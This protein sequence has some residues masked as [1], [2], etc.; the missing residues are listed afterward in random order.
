MSSQ[1]FC[2]SF[3][4]AP[5]LL[6][7]ITLPPETW[8]SILVHRIFFPLLYLHI[9]NFIFREE[10]AGLAWIQSFP[11]SSTAS[12]TYIESHHGRLTSLSRRL[13][14]F[15]EHSN[16]LCGI[17]VPSTES[18]SAYTTSLARTRDN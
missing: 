12:F 13:T 7:S 8:L 3:L 6:F 1:S 11:R 18:Q 2:L 14:A 5:F 17:Q 10:Q 4:L 9:L 16:T 15:G